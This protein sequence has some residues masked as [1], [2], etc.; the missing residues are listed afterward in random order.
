MHPAGW[1]ERIPAY[2]G[3][4]ARLQPYFRAHTP[5]AHTLTPQ[6]LR[7]V[8]GNRRTRRKRTSTRGGNM[9]TPRRK[10]LNQDS[11][12]PPARRNNNATKPGLFSTTTKKK[13]TA[14][15][16]NYMFLESRTVYREKTWQ[17]NN[18]RER[19]LTGRDGIRFPYLSWA[20]ALQRDGQSELGRDPTGSGC[21]SPITPPARGWWMGEN[22]SQRGTENRRRI[23][24]PSQPLGGGPAV[25][26][27][28]WTNS[29]REPRL[30]LKGFHK[31]SQTL[32]GRGRE[33][34]TTHNVSANQEYPLC[35]R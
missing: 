34:W 13:N 3:W 31:H 30:T 24:H 21:L 27:S 12:L 18:G 5:F 14:E 32:P 2:I 20:L 11:N 29:W 6:G 4:K 19:L 1:L 22:A 28:W 9:P 33:H 35:T 10:A 8:G 7:P 15:Y 26:I 16:S 17:D 23:P 25:H